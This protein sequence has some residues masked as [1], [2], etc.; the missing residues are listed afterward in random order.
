[1]KKELN[2]YIISSDK[3]IDYFDDIVNYINSNEKRILDF[4]ELNKPPKKINILILNYKNFKSYII[5]KYGEILD[6]VRG[7]TD[8]LSNTIRVL[9]INDQKEF[10]THKDANVDQMKKMILHEIIHQCHNVYHNDY[11]LI[12]W[13]SEG[14]ATNLSN[15]SYQIVNLNK[16]DFNILKNDFG[17]YK[18]NYNYAYTI[19]NYILNNY[20]KE[21]IHKLY[22]NPHYLREKQDIIFKEASNWVNKS[23]H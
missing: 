13:F 6:Y 14:L 19:V 18:G 7:D 20:S 17:R 12:V 3:D 2:N 10:T 23:L 8:S 5:N 4:F 9:N 16:C 22:S 1:M 15:Q 21:E 11:S